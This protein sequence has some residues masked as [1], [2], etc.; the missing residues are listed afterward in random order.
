MHCKISFAN[1]QP[2]CPGRNMLNK[3]LGAWCFTNCPYSLACQLMYWILLNTDESIPVHSELSHFDRIKSDVLRWEIK[4]YFY[5]TRTHMRPWDI[6]VEMETSWYYS[7]DRRVLMRNEINS[8]VEYVTKYRYRYIFQN[9]ERESWFFIHKII[10]LKRYNIHQLFNSEK[11][12]FS[13]RTNV[14]I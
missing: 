1:F 7:W 2:F 8:M 14:A 9:T 11:L 6:I 4:S 3:Y 10:F 5:Q 13:R 12:S